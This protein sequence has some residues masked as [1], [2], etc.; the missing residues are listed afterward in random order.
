MNSVS[1]VATKLAEFVAQLC[2]VMF[3]LSG[4]SLQWNLQFSREGIL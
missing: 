2:S 3:E 1:L 4:K